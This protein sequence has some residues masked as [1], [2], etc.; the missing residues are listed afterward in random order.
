M[1]PSQHTQVRHNKRVHDVGVS[2]Y[3]REHTEIF[4]PTEQARIARV[5][6]EA[7]SL[8]SPMMTDPV[9]LDFGA[10]T[11][12]LTGHLLGV[13]ARVVAADVSRRSLAALRATY[14][15]AQ[16]LEAV[17]VN[18]MD[19]SMFRD[20]VLDMV[21]TYSVLH[22]VPDYLGVV[23]EFV[24]VVKPGG[25]IYIDH[26]CAPV[27]WKGSAAYET[28]RMECQTA[29]GR[30]FFQQLRRDA[31]NVWSCRAWQ[32]FLNRML[33]GL[34]AEGDIHVTQEDHIEWDRI[35]TI[36]RDRCDVVMQE[37][38]L[39][40]REVNPGAPLYRKY[41]HLCADMRMVIWRKRNRDAIEGPLAGWSSS[42]TL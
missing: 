41:E 23:R 9:V 26:E 30:S 32:R 34:S 18:G 25:I 14:A 40:C 20:D 27:V 42:L 31:R 37:D 21:A 19:L 22:H 17:E 33:F 3:E 28:Y 11:G 16:R 7:I 4:N 39:V 13:N 35:E 12:N 6:G 29:Y 5:L 2:S 38:Y 1:K 10:G 8:I 36:L 24:R 15:G